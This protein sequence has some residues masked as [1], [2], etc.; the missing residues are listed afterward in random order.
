MR[1][2]NVN[3]N[4]PSPSPPLMIIKRLLMLLL[5]CS[6]KDRAAATPRRRERESAV[7]TASRTLTVIYLNQDATFNY[8]FPLTLLRVQR[9]IKIS[10]FMSPHLPAP[11]HSS[12]FLKIFFSF[13]LFTFHHP[14]LCTL[15][16]FCSFLCSSSSSCISFHCF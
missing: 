14:S 15:H 12:L 4:R 9:P 16:V 1:V 6:N 7:V 5:M 3:R 2:Y 11:L 10:Y 8:M 13:V